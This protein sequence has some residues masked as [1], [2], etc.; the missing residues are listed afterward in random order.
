MP[1][2]KARKRRLV[3]RQRW[4]EKLKLKEI[5]RSRGVLK[6]MVCKSSKNDEESCTIRIHTLSDAKYKRHTPNNEDQPVSSSKIKSL[7]LLSFPE[8][9]PKLPGPG[10]LTQAAAATAETI[11]NSSQSAPENIIE[12]R[13]EFSIVEDR[14]G[15]VKYEPKHKVLPS[16]SESQQEFSSSPLVERHPPTAT[17]T[18]KYFWR[19]WKVPVAG[20]MML[21]V[22]S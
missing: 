7:D 18:L 17:T 19:M 16:M 9:E 1:T 15:T 11:T 14:Q 8:A 21:K 2:S 10:C 6:K 22:G 12:I 4:R 20:A 5:L 3:A 13:S